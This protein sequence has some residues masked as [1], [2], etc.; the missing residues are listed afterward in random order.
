[1]AAAND[2]LPPLPASRVFK[3]KVDLPILPC[4]R[5]TAPDSFWDKF[6][7]NHTSPARSL[8]D[9]D[10]LEA[11]ALQTNYPHKAILQEVL[12]D[13]RYGAKIGCKGP[14]RQPSR[15]LNAPSAYDNGRRVTDAIASWVQKGF[16]FGPV[17]PE[18]VPKDAKFSGLMTREK[19]DG[20]VR[21]IINLSSPAGISVNDGICSDEFPTT[22]SSTRK[23]LEVL[24]RTGRQSTFCKVD[25]SEA[26]KH[27]SVCSADIALQWFEW[28]GRCFAELC[29]VFGCSSSA[30]IYDRLAKIVL[31]C[32]LNQSRFPSDWVIQHLDDVCAAAPAGSPLLL[33]FDQKFSELAAV[34]GVKLAPRDDPEKSFGPSTS[35]TVL[36]V[37]YNTVDW[38]WA[39]PAE[40][41]GRILHSLRSLI[42]A[43][44]IPLDQL[45]SIVGKILHV[46][47]LLPDGRFHLFHLLKGN[48]ASTDPKYLLSP[49]PELRQQLWFWYTILRTC[50]SVASIPPP[51]PPTPA[52]AVQ[53]Y[54]DAAGG[55]WSSPGLGC[56][57]V[58]AEWWLYLPWSKAINTGR[59]TE[60][61]RRLDRSMSALELVGPLAAICA[62]PA[63]FRNSAVKFWVDNAGS[64]FIWQKGYSMSCDLSTT[65][66]TALATVA[67]NLGCRVE[68]AKIL[69][70][71]TPLAAMSDALSK[72]DFRR[73]RELSRSEGLS[74]PLEPLRAP[75]ELRRWLEDPRP[76][77]DLGSRLLRGIAKRGC[78]VLAL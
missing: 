62:A 21:I 50:S 72:A 63:T 73:F 55:S 26:Y 19:P 47:P 16:A 1:M 13:L 75:L 71:S 31:H 2:P 30:G 76:D 58:S 18:D 14:S 40:K 46:H 60:Q 49:S 67:A 44:T 42:D 10:K 23:W 32:V 45:W 20:S 74:L 17:K 29:L 57:A 15:A 5:S 34:L 56:G 51:F 78:S 70:C 52:W 66:V 28:A 35:G 48:C 6:P 54:T 65:L 33:N 24:Q 61:G 39:I 4:Y 68:I 77:W 59:V 22:M 69:R 11:L 64:V 53:V 12:L 38:T 41:L 43:D 37:H 8:V 9:P 3:P 25:W 7:V 27:I 36:G